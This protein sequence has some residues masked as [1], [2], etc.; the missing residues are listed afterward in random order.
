[1]TQHTKDILA[2]ALREA[3]LEAMAIKA[4]DGFYHDFLS[5]LAFPEIQLVEDLA[6]AAATHK[7]RERIL[8]LRER[9]MDGDFDASIEESEAWAESTEGQDTFGKLIRGK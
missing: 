8:M 4:A 7:N 9:V 6:S 2:D 3:G 1:M 5:P